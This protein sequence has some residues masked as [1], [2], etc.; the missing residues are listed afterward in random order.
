MAEQ[1]ASA[2]REPPVTDA[3]TSPPGARWV[4]WG[5]R[6]SWNVSL[7]L[8][9]LMLF[10]AIWPLGSN[11]WLPFSCV[12]VLLGLVLI[13]LTTLDGRDAGNWLGRLLVPIV[14]GLIVLS[15]AAVQLYIPV[16]HSVA[17][18]AWGILAE[19][20]GEPVGGVIALTP[21][22]GSFELLKLAAAALVF[23]CSFWIC[24]KAPVARQM[25]TALALIGLF[26]ELYAI[27]LLGIRGT[28]SWLVGSEGP[29]PIAN[30]RASG[31]LGSANH[32]G[33]LAAMG[34]LLAAA[35][36]SPALE[37]VV[38]D[39]GIRPFLRTSVQ[40]LF[41][42]E[43]FWVA[44][45][46]IALGAVVLSGSRAAFV[47]LAVALALH[48][49]LT[50]VISL[51]ARRGIGALTLGALL[52]LFFAILVY[53]SGDELWGRFALLATDGDDLRGTLWETCLKGIS[54]SPILGYGLGGFQIYF[55]LSADIGRAIAVD[56]AHSDWLELLFSLGIPAACVWWATIGWINVRL[57]VAIIR[58]RR[59]RHFAALGLSATLLVGLHA[60]TDASLSIPAVS[61]FYAAILGMA[62]AQSY[63]TAERASRT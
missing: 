62:L 38:A 6:E 14:G 37:D 46:A 1:R 41:G 15:W 32:F 27:G 50:I 19:V 33:T 44:G 5:P 49:L 56:Y 3:V 28:H 52:A 42:R 24:R 40:V 25:L 8:L 36:L 30:G 57:L 17:H 13:A 9:V 4:T 39:R 21:G 7:F 54:E 34:T 2:R 51:R 45:F 47:A 63:S 59:D 11:R 12:L 10:V 53:L 55:D 29:F 61:F 31:P 26:Y 48:M 18:P 16:S 60:L 22:R 23:I 58:R 35:K 43:A 20:T